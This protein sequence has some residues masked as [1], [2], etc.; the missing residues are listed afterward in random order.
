M[1][2]SL[3]LLIIY[4]KSPCLDWRGPALPDLSVL[5]IAVGSDAVYAATAQ[6][7]YRSTDDGATWEKLPLGV[8][9]AVVVLGEHEGA[10]YA[11]TEGAGLYRSADG[12]QTWQAWGASLA[13]HSVYALL[14]RPDGGLWAGGDM[15][16]V[17]LQANHH[18]PLADRVGSHLDKTRQEAY[19]ICS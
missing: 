7:L 13:G 8:S 9:A 6:G 19:N 16:L 5:H 10:L 1:S 18:L 15:G 2:D 11:G 17:Q 12:G 3:T 4:G 14:P